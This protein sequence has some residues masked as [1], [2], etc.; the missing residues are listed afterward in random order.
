MGPFRLQTF[1]DVRNVSGVW[2]SHNTLNAV[3]SEIFPNLRNSMVCKN[4]PRVAALLILKD[5]SSAGEEERWEQGDPARKVDLGE[6][7]WKSPLE[8]QGAPT[9]SSCPAVPGIIVHSLFPAGST[10]FGHTQGFGEVCLL[11]LGFY[12]FI[13]AMAQAWPGA[14]SAPDKPGDSSRNIW[15]QGREALA[16]AKSCPG[17]APVDNGWEHKAFWEPFLP[18]TAAWELWGH[19]WG[20]L[21]PRRA[22]L[23]VGLGVGSSRCA[24][25]HTRPHLSWPETAQL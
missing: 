20:S 17:A 14:P 12:R 6:D 23:G 3:I 18:S 8:H 2:V 15:F 1:C 22:G 7:E 13:R 4:H 11:S 9:Q 5:F 19:R 16:P 21:G 24:P 25:A 10:I